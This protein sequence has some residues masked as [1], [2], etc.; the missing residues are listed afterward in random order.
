MKTNEERYRLVDDKYEFTGYTA[1]DIKP[2]LTA[3]LLKHKI[4]SADQY[5][6][7]KV[8]TTKQDARQQ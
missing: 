6:E 1:D 3:L 8:Q 2:K 4:I 7:T 5:N